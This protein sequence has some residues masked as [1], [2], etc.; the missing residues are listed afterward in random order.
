MGGD[1]SSINGDFG[2]LNTSIPTTAATIHISLTLESLIKQSASASTLATS[3]VVL[4]LSVK[5]KFDLAS[6]SKLTRNI[7]SSTITTL[8]SI[9][10]IAG[11]ALTKRQLLQLRLKRSIF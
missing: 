6:L 10:S 7:T 8:P 5:S 11:L 1:I 9:V 4:Q 3:A 2:P